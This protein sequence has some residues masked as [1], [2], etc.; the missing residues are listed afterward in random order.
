MK[1]AYLI[2]RPVMDYEESMTPYFICSTKKVAERVLAKIRK[3]GERA[4]A[5]MPPWAE[6]A[7]ENSDEANAAFDARY[8]YVNQLNGPFGIDFRHSDI[9]VYTYSFP[10]GCVEMMELAVNPKNEQP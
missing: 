7:P 3:W 10:A 8:E 6:N 2:Y 4:V 9:G 1:T 5:N